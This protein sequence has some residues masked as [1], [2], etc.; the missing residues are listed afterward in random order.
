MMKKQTPPA[1]DP[2]ACVAALDGWR[3]KTVAALRAG[4]A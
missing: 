2:D 4:R 1:A 3:R